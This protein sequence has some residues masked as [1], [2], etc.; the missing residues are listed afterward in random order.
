[1]TVS[2]DGKS[3]LTAWG[4]AVI[5]FVVGETI[6]KITMGTVA[7]FAAAIA[8]AMPVHADTSEQD[9]QFLSALRSAGWTIGSASGL[10]TEGH[11]ICN[12]GL[13]HGVSVQEI[14]ANLLSKG[15]SPLDSATLIRES[16]STY[17]AHRQDAIAGIGNDSRPAR[18]ADPNGGSTSRDQTSWNLGQRVGGWP[19][20]R[21]WASGSTANEACR[22]FLRMMLDLPMYERANADDAMAGCVD[23]VEN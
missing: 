5:V 10:V 23:A 3:R 20:T 13:A 4:F 2:H 8:L 12:E 17:C 19:A 16:V 6:N 1:M 7:A 11:M 9:Q 22:Q 15:Y 21:S 14:R 18:P